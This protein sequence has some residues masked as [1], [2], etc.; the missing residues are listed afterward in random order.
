M[1]RPVVALFPKCTFDG[2]KQGTDSF[3]MSSIF[4]DFPQLAG[5][6]APNILAFCKAWGSLQA[7]IK[8]RMAVQKKLSGQPPAPA[9]TPTS[10]PRPAFTNMEVVQL[11]CI[12]ACSPKCASEAAQPAG[13]DPSSP[14]VATF[15]A[16]QTYV[17][18]DSRLEVE[19]ESIPRKFKKDLAKLSLGWGEVLQSLPEQLRQRM[20]QEP[21]KAT[22]AA[23]G[24]PQA[25]AQLQPQAAATAQ[26]P[27]APRK[28]KLEGPA[29]SGVAVE[30]QGGAAA[31]VGRGG[32]SGWPGEAAARRREAAAA[33]QMEVAR[34]GREV[35]VVDSD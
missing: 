25:Q 15:V 2:L 34:A 16:G 17:Q 9:G 7:P 8:S 31:A 29:T 33:A 18:P 27:K 26:T 21:A 3:S 24:Q 5:H 14:G 4:L 32:G 30:Q 19:A 10:K 28:R 11:G 6:T 22:Q 35:I 1:C 12:Y 13:R 23:Q 20:L